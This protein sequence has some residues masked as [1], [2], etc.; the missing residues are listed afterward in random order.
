MQISPR[1]CGLTWARGTTMTA[2]GPVAVSWRLRDGKTLEISSTAPEGVDVQV[3]RNDSL[4]GKNV[5]WNGKEIG[6]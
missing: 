3:V 4:K 1:L 2:R 5:I 6:G